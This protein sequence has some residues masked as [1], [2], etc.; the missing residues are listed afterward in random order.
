MSYNRYIGRKCNFCGYRQNVGVKGVFNKHPINLGS[1]IVCPGSYQPPEAK[2][3]P[4]IEPT[5]AELNVSR[6]IL[7]GLLHKFT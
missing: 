7:G 2:P 3:E 4:V 6:S 5:A 1:K